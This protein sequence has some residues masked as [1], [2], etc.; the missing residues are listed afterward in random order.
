MIYSTKIS[1]NSD[2]ESKGTEIVDIYKTV[3]L[4]NCD[5]DH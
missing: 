2:T 1:R 3:A 4:L 5:P